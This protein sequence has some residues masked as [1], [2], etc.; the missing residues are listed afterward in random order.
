MNRRKNNPRGMNDK[1]VNHPLEMSTADMPLTP[2]T[3]S[4]RPTTPNKGIFMLDS[5]YSYFKEELFGMDCY[6]NSYFFI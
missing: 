4:K 6:P 5:V 2:P 1:K 3:T